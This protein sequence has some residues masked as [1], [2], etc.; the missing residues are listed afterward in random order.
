MDNQKSPHILNAASNLLG[1]CFILLTSFK[2]FKLGAGTLYDEFI[3]VSIL[4]FM[5]SCILSFLAIRNSMKPNSR[6]EQLA[7][8]F[9]MSGLISLFVITI[10]FA[11]SII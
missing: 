8:Y 4:L 2:V 10:L 3:V 1:I 7:D 11:T 9:F 6:Y 5:S